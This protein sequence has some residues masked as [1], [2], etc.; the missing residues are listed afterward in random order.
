MQIGGPLPYAGPLAT[1][2]NVV[3]IA[4]TVEQLGYDYVEVGE[5]LLYPT[6]IESRYP[7]TPD[8]SL[9][10]DPAAN[11]LEIFSLLSFVAA[12]TTRLRLHSGILVLPYRSPFV[13][14]KLAATLD[15][16]SDGRLTLGVGVGWMKDEFDI[17]GVP[18][19]RRGAL[20]D[21]SLEILRA[22]FEGRS[23][24]ATAHYEFGE[25]HFEP[26]P[27]Q[28]P[29]PIWVA[30]RG[31]AALR[32]VA[33]Y[34]QGWFPVT[35]PEQLPPELEQLRRQ[36]DKEGRGGDTIDVVTA[37]IVD[38]EG[39]SGIPGMPGVSNADEM[40]EHVGR[41]VEAGVTT[42]HVFSNELYGDS[43][44]Q[45]L[46]EAQWFAEEVMPQLR[47]MSLQSDL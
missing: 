26:K 2:D 9:P 27:V 40:L 22:L 13:V 20:T 39:R 32:R 15:F 46:D 4:T 7:Y 43:V 1:R 38:L 33:R 31:P 30:G 34:G 42:V 14:A 35:T 36:L 44:A 8:G 23:P 6:V 41:W 25:V 47:R 19:E 29:L 12:H 28:S 18:W 3:K 45:V 21:E 37:V 5:H 11:S 24:V 10:L 17:I 16:L